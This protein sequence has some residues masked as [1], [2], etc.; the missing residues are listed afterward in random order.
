M[1][2]EGKLSSSFTINYQKTGTQHEACY[3]LNS[4]LNIDSHFFSHDKMFCLY[5]SRTHT[6]TDTKLFSSSF[7]HIL[8]LISLLIT[9]LSLIYQHVCTAWLLRL[10]W[11]FRFRPDIE[12][13]ANLPLSRVMFRHSSLPMS[14]WQRYRSKAECNVKSVSSSTFLHQRNAGDLHAK[15]IGAVMDFKAKQS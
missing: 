5:H 13:H 10:D 11:R 6:I 15:G 9:L 1:K 8:S 2:A 12:I 7:W 3:R 4:S 14:I